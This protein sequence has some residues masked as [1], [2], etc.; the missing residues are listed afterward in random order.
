M[1]PGHALIPTF[2]HLNAEYNW[3]F[4]T[5]VILAFGLALIRRPVLLVIYLIAACAFSCF[6]DLVYP[7]QFRHQGVF[8]IFWL[9][10][11]WVDRSLEQNQPR[12]GRA[13]VMWYRYAVPSIVLLLMS[14]QACLAYSTV[15]N[16]FEKENSSANLVGD[17]V[18]S[19]PEWKNAVLSGSRIL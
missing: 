8:Y 7:L 18:R 10:C 17:L 9:C 5:F 14:W 4:R 19:H 1:S 3:A 15:D 11:V 13:T 6:S 16:Q 2:G 12:V